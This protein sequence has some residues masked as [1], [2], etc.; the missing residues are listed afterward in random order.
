MLNVMKCFMKGILQQ[1]T[2]QEKAD[3][4][5][6]HVVE[7]DPRR[8]N[9]PVVLASPSKENEKTV[10]NDEYEEYMNQQLLVRDVKKLNKSN[11]SSFYKAIS[12]NNR[13]IP[14]PV[15]Q[16]VPEE[17]SEI[18]HLTLDPSEIAAEMK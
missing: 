16:W 5:G 17:L 9:Y 14:V 13:G 3:R 1:E 11:W 12:S 8:K 6:Y 2:Y 18:K 4:L 7:F 10:P 15:C